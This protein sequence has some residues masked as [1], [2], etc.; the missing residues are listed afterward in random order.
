MKPTSNVYQKH[1][2]LDKRIKI[3]KGLKKVKILPKLLMIFANL[4]KRFLMKLKEIELLN[5]VL[6][7]M[8]KKRFVT[9]P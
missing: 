4:L 6:L 7:G 1:L 8:E 3:E 5:I 2:T 9:K